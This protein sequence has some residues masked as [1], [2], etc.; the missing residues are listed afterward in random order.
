MFFDCDQ[1]F[2]IGQF[3]KLHEINKKTLMWYD[4]VGILKPAVVGPNGYR[5]YTY[6][7][8]SVLE[9]ILLMRELN[10]SLPEIQHFLDDRS[11]LSLETLLT[12]KIT[13]LDRTIAHLRSIRSVMEQKRQNMSRLR[14]LDLSHMEV[15]EKPEAHYLATVATTADTPFEKEIE[16]VMGEVRKYQLH[17]LHDVSYGSMLPVENLYQGRFDAYSFLYMELPARVHRRG[18]HIQPRGKYIRAFYKGDWDG[19]SGRYEEIL[20]YAERHDLQ[21]SGF[22]YERGINELVIDTIDDYITQ[23]EIPIKEG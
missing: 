14:T 19:I 21:F 3:A 18:L 5:Y 10:M 22:A 17:R 8:S 7:Q 2:T 4:E 1:L 15:I 13:E 16:M 20:A 6:Q 11:A 9:V 12:D 23:I